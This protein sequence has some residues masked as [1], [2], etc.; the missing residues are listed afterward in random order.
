VSEWCKLNN[1][2]G[3][4]KPRVPSSELTLFERFDFGGS[5][6]QFS[7]QLAR[8]ISMA[9][10]LGRLALVG[11]TNLVFVG[12][13]VME[14]TFISLL[15]DGMRSSPSKAFGESLPSAGAVWIVGSP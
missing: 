15:C 9:R 2:E 3:S 13:S 7:N 5:A 4:A 11:R 10:L 1:Q 14:N 8:D 6:G 12:D